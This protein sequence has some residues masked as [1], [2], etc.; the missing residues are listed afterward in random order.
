MLRVRTEFLGTSGTP[1]LST[2]Y[3]GTDAT[4]ADADNAVDAV[5]DFWQGLNGVM[6]PPLTWAT[7]AQVAVIT[8][9]GVVT[10]AFTTTPRTGAGIQ[11][12]DMLPQAL[13]G[14]VRWRTN[15]FVGG[16]EI[17]GHTNVP[18]LSE[19]SQVAG[20]INSANLTTI[21]TAAQAL[22]ARVDNQLM[23]WSRVNN[24][25]I[26]VQTATVWDRFAVLRSRRD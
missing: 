18:C 20:V 4:Q 15:S 7:L 13:Q 9:A 8:P 21:N 1:Y 2:M 3:F 14:L 10:G 12:G 19:S 22:N 11:T 17:Q 23:V 26:A 16:R 5:G 25:A 24:S 6:C